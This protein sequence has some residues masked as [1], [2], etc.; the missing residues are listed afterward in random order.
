MLKLQT[1]PLEVQMACLQDKRN[2]LP[3]LPNVYEDT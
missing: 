2:T 1:P 3:E